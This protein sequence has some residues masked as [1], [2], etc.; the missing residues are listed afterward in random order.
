[1][2]FKR[3]VVTIVV[4]I[5]AFVLPA[6]KKSVY[7]HP[8]D[9]NEAETLFRGSSHAIV[10]YLFSKS[11]IYEVDQKVVLKEAFVNPYQ[12]DFRL[13]LR[14]S[15]DAIQVITDLPEI[16]V[17]VYKSLPANLD[18]GFIEGNVSIEDG[19]GV[20]ESLKHTVGVPLVY[21]VG[22]LPLGYKYLINIDDRYHVE[23]PEEVMGYLLEG[24]V[25]YTNAA[26]PNSEDRQLDVYRIYR[27][28]KQ[29]K[30]I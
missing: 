15:G 19:R 27:Q 12:G 25:K 9:S 18:A 29:Q 16:G 28:I 22:V 7:I 10:E 23:S 1:M 3:S 14:F 8:E 4:L 17:L 11:S 13:N 20:I 24:L 30:L 5:A 26:E 2:T 21:R 6:C